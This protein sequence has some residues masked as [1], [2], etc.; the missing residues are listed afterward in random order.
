MAETKKSSGGGFTAEERAAMKERAKEL[1]AEKE[2][3][4]KEQDEAA[5]LEKISE[6]KDADRAMATRIHE[7]VKAVAPQLT[8]RLWYGSPAYAKDGKVV[9]FFQDSNKFKTRYA[10]VGFSDEAALDDGTM[11]PNSYALTEITPDVVTRVRD[12]LT[13]AVS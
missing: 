9:C 10:T 7:I 8:S 2:A 6:M 3:K 4:S 1:K 13:R 11:W 5:V 12:L